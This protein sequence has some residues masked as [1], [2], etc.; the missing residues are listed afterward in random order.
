MTSCCAV[1]LFLVLLFSSCSSTYPLIIDVQEPASI[2][3]P[4]SVSEVLVVN[5]TVSQPGNEGIIRTYRGKEIETSAVNMDS[6]SWVVVESLISHINSAHFFDEVLCYL[7]PVRDDKEWLTGIALPKDFRQEIFKT[8]NVDAIISID[9]VLFK[10]SQNTKDNGYHELP[11]DKDIRL[12]TTSLLDVSVD[13]RIE[14]I[15]NC[16][17][18]LL[19]KEYPLSSFAVSD[20][21][22]YKISFIADFQ[23]VFKNMPESLIDNLAFALGEKLADKMVPSWTTKERIFYTGADSRMQ[24]A[25][26]YTKSGKW[27]IAESLWLKEYNIRPKNID[28]GKISNNIAISCEMQDKWDEA[29]IW[30][31]KAKE[32]FNDAGF[33]EESKEAVQITAYIFDLQ[34]RI[35]DNYLLDIQWG[36]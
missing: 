5:N 10:M 28:K 13:N 25:F 21:L 3:F 31:Q 20:S 34:K 23:T 6:V 16:S 11:K 24:E 9:R 15:V 27:S 33:S 32:H 12:D 14:A 18:Y 2:T 7:N 35:Q 29:L 30:A 19:G 1:L 4:P 8:Q 22:S 26:S 36:K 17:V